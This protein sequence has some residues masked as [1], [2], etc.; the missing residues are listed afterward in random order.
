[1]SANDVLIHEYLDEM[2]EAVPELGIPTEFESLVWAARERDDAE[3]GDLA[4]E[5]AVAREWDR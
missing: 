2:A 4:D 5:L 1:M 3:A